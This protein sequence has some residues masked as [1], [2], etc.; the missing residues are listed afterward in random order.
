MSTADFEQMY[1]QLR[2]GAPC[3]SRHGL[4]VL[5]RTGVASWMTLLSASDKRVFDVNRVVSRS[6]VGP[7]HQE[8]IQVV[9]SMITANLQGVHS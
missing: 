5:V 3:G 7:F 2:I 8:V 9:A 6:S 1:E 4:A